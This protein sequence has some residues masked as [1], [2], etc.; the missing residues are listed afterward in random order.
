[1][2]RTLLNASNVWSL[3]RP[4]FGKTT[5]AFRHAAKATLSTMEFAISAQPGA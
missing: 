5:I 4:L 2:G 1:M 3:L